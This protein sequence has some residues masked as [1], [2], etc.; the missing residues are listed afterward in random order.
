MSSISQPSP[1]YSDPGGQ[2]SDSMTRDIVIVHV[3]GRRFGIDIN[4]I[5]EIIP[6]VEPKPIVNAPNY[7]EGV[8]NLR[9]SMLPTVKLRRILNFP[10]KPIDPDMFVIISRVIENRIGLIVEGIERTMK[11]SIQDKSSQ[12]HSMDSHY[13]KGIT[14]LDG[15]LME[16]LELSEILGRVE[17]TYL[18]HDFTDTDDQ[19][20]YAT[21]ED[22][23][24][25]AMAPSMDERSQKILRERAKSLAKSAIHKREE[26]ERWMSFSLNGKGYAVSAAYMDEVIG[27]FKITGLPSL[28]LHC[29]GIISLRG[30]I[31]PI[32]DMKGMLR[33][34]IISEEDVVDGEVVMILRE[35]DR[36]S[37]FLVDEVKRNIDLEAKTIQIPF[38]TSEN[39]SSEIIIGQVITEDGL[40]VILDAKKMIDKFHA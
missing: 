23:Q 32:L 31:V 3:E 13:L 5:E 10:P 22:S 19:S 17:K 27:N 21:T 16:V 35:D 11:L 7:I 34:D 15:E 8:I 24:G 2:N 37:G 30:D 36:R 9:G 1:A 6:M 33:L 28:P 4:E 38:T 12:D 40:L 25:S 26:K 39:L 14:D 18:Q 29:V 20:T